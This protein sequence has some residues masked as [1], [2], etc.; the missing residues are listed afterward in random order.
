[1]LIMGIKD[2]NTLIDCLYK[3]NFQLTYNLGFNLI[4]D[5]C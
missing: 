2:I 3:K 4:I 1:M 5:K